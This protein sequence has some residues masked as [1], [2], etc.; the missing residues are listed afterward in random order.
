MNKFN[1]MNEFFEGDFDA[2]DD[3]EERENV[4]G[5]GFVYRVNL[6]EP[7]DRVSQTF[8]VVNGRLTICLEFEFDEFDLLDSPDDM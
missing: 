6:P 5:P 1:R 8:K 3:I 7:P 2:N 4:S